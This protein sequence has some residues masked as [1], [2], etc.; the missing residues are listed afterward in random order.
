LAQAGANP[1]TTAGWLMDVNAACGNPMKMLHPCL[2]GRSGMLREIHH[3][4]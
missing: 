3:E 1:A 4:Y 2:K